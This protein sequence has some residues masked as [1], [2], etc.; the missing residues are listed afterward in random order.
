MTGFTTINGKRPVFE[1][2]EVRVLQGEKRMV[3]NGNPR[4]KNRNGPGKAEGNSRL[5]DT[6][7]GKASTRVPRI[8]KLLSTIHKRIFGDRTTSKQPFKERLKI[9]MDSGLP[10]GLRQ[11]KKE[12]YQ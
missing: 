8:W 10:G 2:K 3:R 9:R 1:T 12:V 4:R 7:N 6:D 11:P 5:A